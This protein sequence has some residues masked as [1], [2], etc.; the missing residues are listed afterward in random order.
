MLR[1]FFM[2]L[3]ERFHNLL[4]VDVWNRL[5]VIHIFGQYYLV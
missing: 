5:M 1:L 2:F 4:S 3:L